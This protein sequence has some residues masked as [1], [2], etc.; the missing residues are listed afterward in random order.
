MFIDEINTQVEPLTDREFQVLDL[1]SRGLSNREI[2]DELVVAPGTIKWYNKQIYRKLGVNSRTKAVAQ[3]NKAGLLDQS[4]KI[5]SIPTVAYNHNFPSPITSFIGREQEMIEIKQLMDDH[6]LLTLTGPGGSG[7]SRLAQ[8]IAADVVD[9]YIDG[10]FIVDLAPIR[11]SELVPGTIA[12]TL[13]IREVPGEPLVETLK[14]S[15]AGKR[16]M[17]ILDNF[18]QIIDA[19]PLVSE[20]LSVSPY[21]KV[22]VTS[23]EALA[24]Y[25]EQVYSVPS[26]SIPDLQHLEP[27]QRVLEYESVQLFYQRAK[28]VKPDFSIN[29]ENIS[30]IAEVC[31]RLDG[32]PLAIELAAARSNLYSP[33]MIRKRLDSRLTIL[34]ST[35]RDVPIR[36][37]TLRATLDWSYDL[38]DPEEQ[39]LLARLAVFKGGRTVDSTAAVCA[40]GLQI[41]VMDGLESLLNK[42]MLYQEQGLLGEPRFYMLETIHE[43]AQE[44]LV[45]NG[46]AEDIELLH[47]QYF[48]NLALEAEQE[49]YGPRQEYWLTRLREEYDNLRTAMGYSLDGGDLLLVFQI[50]GALRYLWFSDGLVA[51]GFKWIERALDFEGE[52]PPVLRAKVYITAADLSYIQGNLENGKLF[53]RKALNLAQESGHELTQ[54]WALVSLGKNFS[55][56]RDQVPNGILFC[57]ESLTLFRKLNYVP[58]ITITLNV[59]GELARVDRNYDLAEK[60]YQQC[61]KLSRRACDKRR[62]AVSL[63]NLAS[64]A[65]YHGEYHQAELLERESIKME[66]ELGTKYYLGLSFACLSGIIAVQGRPEQAAILMGASESVLQKMGGKLQ[67]ADQIEVDHYLAIIQEKL[68]VKSFETALDKGRAMSFDQA[69][70]LVFN[71]QPV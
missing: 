36:Q 64:I 39:T 67:P 17:L 41:D 52:I 40:S 21:L 10:V 48:T 26:L 5:T 57:E 15:L 56:S 34:T 47:S 11:D 45:E 50:I 12:S 27:V 22:L 2:A 1:I 6:R 20:L 9:Q 44:K 55:K 62:I 43:Y 25:G 58:G 8:Q 24:I 59:L 4:R 60:Y 46:K 38:L 14:F 19:A 28:A 69:L 63:A 32:L 29:D 68:D 16:E 7:K 23:R 71:D 65:M 35:F 51:E 18:E 54:A 49:L 13:D 70:S 66:V 30:S 37:Q 33:E 3:A 61:L 53:G 42:N 31:V